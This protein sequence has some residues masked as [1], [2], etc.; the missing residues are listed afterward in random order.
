MNP[1]KEEIRELRKERKEE[2]RKIEEHTKSRSSKNKK[3]AYGALILIV[4]AFVGI[5][6]SGLQLNYPVTGSS[7]VSG[8][9]S[10]SYVKGDPEAPVTI[11]E[12]SDFQ[13]PFCA[14][15]V[16][17]TLPQIEEQYI[18]TGKVKLVFK[19]FPLVQTHQ[20]ASKAAEASVCA[21]DQG[22]F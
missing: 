20:F 5:A 22:K 19:H 10:G 17:Q 16:S 11:M 4:I 3:I 6:Y 8:V 15:F 2:E 13:C 9:E 14:R 1:S 7:I 12:F 21:G 18:S